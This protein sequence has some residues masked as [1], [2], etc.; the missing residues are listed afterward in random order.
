MSV[1][2]VWFRMTLGAFLASVLVQQERAFAQLIGNRPV[3]NPTSSAQQRPAN[4]PNTPGMGSGLTGGLSPLSPTLTLQNGPKRYLRGNRSRLDFV[5]S[6]RTDLSGF[7]GSEQALGV[8][9]VPSAADSL[10]LETTRNAKTNK[11][12]P[13]QPAK[14]MYYPRL[15]IAFDTTPSQGELLPVGDASMDIRERVAQVSGGSVN[16]MMSGNTAIL[17][18]TVSSVRTSEL[19]T[20]LLT[21]EPGVNGVKNELV[22]K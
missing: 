6:N 10:R 17:R 12:L 3:S 7:V 16:V 2:R 9:G 4:N 11:P 19:L 15:E 20:Q 18:G 21:F 1:R 13:A 8:G 5:G 22:V 14:G